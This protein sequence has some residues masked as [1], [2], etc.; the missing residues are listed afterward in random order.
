MSR[1][2][3]SIDRLRISDLNKFI[4]SIV[5]VRFVSDSSMTVINDL[6]IIQP[7]RI[8]LKEIR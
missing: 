7:L 8:L 6:L 5:T 3:Q 2:H 4:S 1:Y